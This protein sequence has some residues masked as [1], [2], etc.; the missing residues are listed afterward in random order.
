MQQVTIQ[1][2]RIIVTQRGGST[3]LL[4][5]YAYACRYST[6]G[7]SPPGLEPLYYTVSVF[8][9]EGKGPVNLDTGERQD[10]YVFDL[11]FVEKT[12]QPTWNNTEQGAENAVLAITPFL[13]AEECCPSGTPG[14][15]IA[16]NQAQCWNL[17]DPTWGLQP[18]QLIDC[19]IPSIDFCDPEFLAAL[20]EEQLVCIIPT[21]DPLTV[22]WD[23]DGTIIDIEVYPD[24][25]GGEAVLS[26]DTLIDAVVVEGAGTEDANTLYFRNGT[27]NGEP[28]YQSAL[29]YVIHYEPFGVDD[30]RWSID[31]DLN[32]S[33]YT[34]SES[35]GELFGRTW[36]LANGSEPAPTVRQATI[37]DLCCSGGGPAE[38]CPITISVNGDELATVADPCAT[39][40]VNYEAVDSEGDPINTAIVDGK[41]VALDLPCAP[42]EDVTIQL[43]DTAANNIGA[44]DVYTAGT[45]TTKTAPDGT[46]QRKDSAG[47]DIGSPIAVRS[48]QTGVVATCP[49]AT[50]VVKNLNGTTLVTEAILSNASEN[51]TAP[52]PLKFAWGAGNADTLTFTVTDDE[53]GTY[54]N[55]TQDGSSGTITYSKNGAAYATVTGSISLAIGDTISLR[56][57]TPTSQGF[58]RW[59]L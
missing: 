43:R 19:V 18:E 12:S 36:I 50:A 33:L 17:L 13:R 23:V 37:G 4:G 6:A 20:T 27:H 14:A 51:I 16:V 32:D 55:Y 24:P 1:S 38:P 29:N 25:C 54:A 48:N 57:T 44:P 28:E 45:T 59:A 46:F 42:C 8:F 40:S 21:C 26:C 11:R 15:V 35:G 7:A 10:E 49:D 3:I 41:I 39:P 9:D 5:K 56:R 58:S 47:T 30:S 53:A 2:D 31:D 52:I 34:T 22:K